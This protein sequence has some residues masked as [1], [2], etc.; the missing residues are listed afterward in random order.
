MVFDQ[1][2]IGLL[3]GG[4]QLSRNMVF[5]VAKLLILPVAAFALHDAL[6]VGITLSW[7]AGT[8]VSIAPVAIWLWFHRQPVLPRPD[9]GVLRGLGRT[10]MA[11]NWLNLSIG[12]PQTVIPVLV[13]VVVSP[14]ANAAF[15]V[16]WMLAS[17]LYIVPAHL[18]TVLFA[19][20]SADPRSV[21]RKIRFTLLLSLLIGIPGMIVLGLGSRLALSMFGSGYAHA[22][23]L[24]LLLLVIGYLP[25]IP[26]S[27]YIAVCRAAG[28]VPRAAVVLTVGTAMELTAAAIGGTLG[29][30]VGLSF[31]LLGIRVLEGLVTT[32]AVLIAARG[33]GRHRYDG[34]LSAVPEDAASAASIDAGTWERQQAGIAMLLSLATP[35]ATQPIPSQAYRRPGSA[36]HRPERRNAVHFQRRLTPPDH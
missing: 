14:S 36:R 22:A 11:H 31:A 8:A 16:A 6:G 3:R 17:F 2:T 20:A 34:S 35:A 28:K 4:L 32:P 27:H 15:Y 18:S 21:S 5:S 12:I 29:G 13:T 30:L 7:M 25:A 33:Q 9:W 26:R 10:T 19:V 23:A 1:A 24:P